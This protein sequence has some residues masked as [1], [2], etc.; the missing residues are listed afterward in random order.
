MYLRF[1]LI[2]YG[3]VTDMETTAFERKAYYLKFPE[4]EVCHKTQGHMGKYQGSSSGRGMNEKTQTRVLIT[5]FAQR[6]Q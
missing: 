1:V 4:K 3:K 2:T 6:I 5:V